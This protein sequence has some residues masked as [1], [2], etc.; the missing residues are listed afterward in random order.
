MA[1]DTRRLRGTP[2]EAQA[3][4]KA[5]MAR[6]AQGRPERADGKLTA[7][8]LAQEAG[9]SRKQLYHYF[10]TVPSL[11][12]AWRELRDQRKDRPPEASTAAVNR[13]IRELE[14]QVDA[15]KSV[16]AVAR[17]EA[18]RNAETNETLR[19]ENE[20]LRGALHATVG[21]VVRL[22]PR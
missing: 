6:L 17:A 4:I 15:W 10:D 21:Q 5:A 18:E 7:T 9:M 8:S 22:V 11:A 2:E 3:D 13:R 19:A 1:T 20:R 16:A 14:Q 12:A